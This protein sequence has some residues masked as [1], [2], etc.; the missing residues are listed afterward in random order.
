[1]E[2]EFKINKYITLKLEGETTVI[3]VNGE[4]YNICKR[5]LINIP[6]EKISKL[7]EIESIDEAAEKSGGEFIETEKELII[8]PEVEFWAHCSVRHEAV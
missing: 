8:P 1:M 5:L 4:R 2:K 6:V 7:D 3:Y